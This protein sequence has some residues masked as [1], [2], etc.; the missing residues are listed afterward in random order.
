VV[1]ERDVEIL[2]LAGLLRRVSVDMVA[3]EIFPASV[4]RARRSIR[5]L[6]D[7]ALLDV[8]VVDSRAPSVVS[9]TKRGLAVLASREPDVAWRVRL[10]GPVRLDALD[11]VLLLNCTRLYGAAIGRLRNAPLVQ[12]SNGGRSAGAE[13]AGLGLEP[14]A[15]AVFGTPEGSVRVAVELDL[16]GARDELLHRRLPRY[17]HV[18][19]RGQ[20]DALWVITMTEHRALACRERLAELGLDEWARVLDRQHLVARPVRELPARDRAPDTATQDARVE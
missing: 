6:Y 16:A 19:H 20:L 15:V 17:R 18:A 9:L 1:T 14:D 10:P 3:R 13:F 11:R 7:A 2:A 12:W 4:D 5:R 8:V